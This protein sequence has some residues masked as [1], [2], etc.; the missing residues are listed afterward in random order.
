MLQLEVIVVL[1]S[2]R[3]ETY[4]LDFHF[5]LLGFHFLGMLLLL[6]KEF[7]IVN[8]TTNR[9]LRIRRDFNKINALCSCHIQCLACGHYGGTVFA[10]Y[11]Y[12]PY[13]NLFIHAVLILYFVVLHST[14]F[15]KRM[16]SYHI[17]VN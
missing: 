7:A 14:I 6:I 16:Q 4:F 12:F 9:R 15:D 10:N 11:S 8:K 3:S 17:S 5:S 1:I 13:A 2:L